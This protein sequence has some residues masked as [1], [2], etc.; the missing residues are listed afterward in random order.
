M[1]ETFRFCF[2]VDLHNMFQPP[3]GSGTF[4]VLTNE[5]NYQKSF[6]QFQKIIKQLIILFAFFSIKFNFVINYLKNK[7]MPTYVK[8]QKKIVSD[9]KS[10]V[11]LTFVFSESQNECLYI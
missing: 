5:I 11:I 4:Q 6:S 2:I 1:T 7:I 9:I 8:C 3:T 10:N